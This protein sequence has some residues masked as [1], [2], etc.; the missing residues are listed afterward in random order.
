MDGVLASELVDELGAP[1]LLGRTLAEGAVG[2][3]ECGCEDLTVDG[4]LVRVGGVRGDV[5]SERGSIG[6]LSAWQDSHVERHEQ[7]EVKSEVGR[8]LVPTDA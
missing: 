6:S 1:A 7:L 5:V 3:R 8:S 2:A 4:E